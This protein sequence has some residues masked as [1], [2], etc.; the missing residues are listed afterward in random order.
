MDCLDCLYCKI[1]VCRGIIRCKKGLWKKDNGE[2]KIV[3]LSAHET[4]TLNIGW[5]NIFSQGQ[6]CGSRF[7]MN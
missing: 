3:K 4:R 5:H 2:D 6:N 1:R 7:L